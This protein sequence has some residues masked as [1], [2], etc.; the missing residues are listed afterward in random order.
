MA[1][2]ITFVFAQ[3]GRLN[4]LPTSIYVKTSRAITNCICLSLC[5]SCCAAVCTFWCPCLPCMQRY[6][7]IEA[8]GAP[9]SQHFLFVRGALR[10]AL[11]SVRVLVEPFRKVNSGLSDRA[12]VRLC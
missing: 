4:A 1:E 5:A 3:W 6:L 11:P 9:L 2:G 10:S 7:A 12:R 8:H